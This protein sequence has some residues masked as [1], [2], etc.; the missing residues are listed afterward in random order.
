LYNHERPHE[1][2]GMCTPVERY[3]PSPR[4]MPAQPLQPQYERHDLVRRVQHGGWV[5]VLGRAVRLSSALHGR[6]VALRARADQDGVYDVFFYK[7]KV[8]SID[9][10][11]FD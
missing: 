6:S 7:Q 10:T 4:A 9:L 1:A 2:L 11:A 5:S 3:R 8:D